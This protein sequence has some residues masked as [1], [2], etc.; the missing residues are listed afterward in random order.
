[1]IGI[2]EVRATR[3]A[4]RRTGLL[5]FPYAAFVDGAW[6]VLRVNHGFPEHD[7]YT[8]FV[9]GTAVADATP[10]RGSFPFDAS[11]AQLEQL[12]KGRGPQVEPAVAHAAIAPIAALA[13]YG[14]ENGDTCDFCFGDKDGYAPM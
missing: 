13:D 3:P 12:S 11:L 5:Y 2:D 8:V 7:L 1:M 14:S 10:G 4:W 9:D 6:W